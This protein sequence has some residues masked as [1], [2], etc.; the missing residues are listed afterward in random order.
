MRT[1]RMTEDAVICVR[2]ADVSAPSSISS[3]A[4]LIAAA[5]ESR[6]RD[7]APAESVPVIM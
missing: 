6:F 3:S 2:N 4:F 5:A 1:L 7:N